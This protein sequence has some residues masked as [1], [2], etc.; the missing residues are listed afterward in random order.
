MNTYDWKP[1]GI[2]FSKSI[3][4]TN[5]IYWL[6]SDRQTCLCFA[7]VDRSRASVSSLWK[8]FTCAQ[9]TLCLL[10]ITHS[11]SHQPKSRPIEWYVGRT[12]FRSIHGWISREHKLS[13]CKWSFIAEQ[14]SS[15]YELE[16]AFL[17][18]WLLHI[19]P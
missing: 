10:F 2:E 16:G 12:L 17:L 19:W 5:F 9:V 3:H 11:Y 4:I 7:I 8:P 6:N 15:S 18:S 14:A 1:F 13:S